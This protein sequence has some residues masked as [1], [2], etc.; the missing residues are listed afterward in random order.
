ME[1]A[2]QQT[3]WHAAI[4]FATG[5]SP[6]ATGSAHILTAPYQAF[7]ASDGW[8]NV[9]G[10]NQANWERIA[11]VL[12]HP[13]WRTDPR[14]ATNAARMANLSAL[15]AAMNAVIATRTRRHWIEAFDAAGV[16]VGPVNT[17]GEALSHPQTL[18]RGMVVDLDHPRAGR[19]KALGCPLHFSKTP[20]AVK[21]PAPLLGEHTREVLREIGY[22]D[23]EIDRFVTEGVVEKSQSY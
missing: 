8:I 14:F 12:G 15:T 16:P 13:E 21:R 7:R 4:Y 6:G 18:A 10:A 2:L 23:A 19:T 3:Y 5:Q 11:D 17:I 20:T 9:G 22:Q 1:A